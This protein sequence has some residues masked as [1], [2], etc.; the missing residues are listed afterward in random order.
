MARE[1][2]EEKE[3]NS[4]AT[5]LPPRKRSKQ[6][7]KETVSSSSLP[8]TGGFNW[9]LEEQSRRERSKYTCQNPIRRSFYS[10]LLRVDMYCVYSV[11]CE[12]T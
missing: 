3:K 5:K 6:K 2:K 9:L 4:L 11:F 1:E 7:E 12:V 8:T 10:T